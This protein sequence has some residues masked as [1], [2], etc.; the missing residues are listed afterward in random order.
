MKNRFKVLCGAVALAVAG[1]VSAATSWTLNTGSVAGDNSAVTAASTG[2]ANTGAGASADAQVLESQPAGTNLALYGG[3]LGIN[4]L[5]GCVSASGICDVGD[6]ASTAPEHAIDNNQR[7]E[8]VLLSFAQSVKLTNAKFGWTGTSDYAASGG[9]SDYTVLAYT[10][11]GAPVLAGKTWA[12]LGAVGSGW[13]KIGNYANATDGTNN[14]INSGSSPVFSSYWLIGAYNP[15]AGGTS[16]DSSINIGNDYL[17]LQ[18]VTGCVS[19]TVGCA[20]PGRVPEPGSL[21]LFGLALLG[22]LGLR[23]RQQA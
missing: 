11:S 13:G 22:M 14:A 19:G 12:D 8:M 5:D 16:T 23:K 15:L 20:P 18:S 6:I 2:W 7:Y 9:D 4:N 1:Q 17:K 3:G 21:A 10:G